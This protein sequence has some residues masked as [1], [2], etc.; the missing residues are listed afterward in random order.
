VAAGVDT[1]E[2]GHELTYLLAT[3]LA[4]TGRALVP[5]LFVYRQIAEQPNIPEYAQ[6]KARKKNS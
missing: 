3:E 4:T 6:E 5:T 2:H 1:I